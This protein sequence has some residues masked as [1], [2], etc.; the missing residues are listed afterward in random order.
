MIGYGDLNVAEIFFDCQ[1]P[2]TKEQAESI[3][4]SL[5]YPFSPKWAGISCLCWQREAQLSDGPWIA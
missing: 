4:I 5:K 2:E 1:M 3:G